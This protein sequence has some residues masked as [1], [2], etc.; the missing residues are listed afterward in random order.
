MRVGVV[1]ENGEVDAAQTLSTYW[2][3]VRSLE[4]LPMPATLRSAWLAHCAG[5]L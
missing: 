1:R 2:R 3:T 5:W 4:K